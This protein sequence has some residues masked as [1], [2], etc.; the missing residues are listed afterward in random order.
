VV[1][2]PLT[3]SHDVTNATVMD[4]V[5][6]IIANPEAI[7]VNQAWAGHSGSPFKRSLES[8]HLK[9]REGKK[10]IAFETAAW[11]YFYKPLVLDSASGRATKVHHLDIVIVIGALSFV[12][13]AREK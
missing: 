3:L 6:P 5:W 13:G 12:L 10:V 8:V 4:A 11:Q 2:S 1:S 7:A 9:H